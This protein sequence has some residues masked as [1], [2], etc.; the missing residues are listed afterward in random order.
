M[1]NKGKYVDRNPTIRSAGVILEPNDTVGNTLK[2]YSPE[3]IAANIMLLKCKKQ[4]QELQENSSL[5]YSPFLPNETLK[6][7]LSPELKKSRFV[8]FR[9]KFAEDMFFKK[10]V[11]GKVLQVHSKPED[12]TNESFVYGNR[13]PKSEKAYE[14]VLPK[15]TA[16][17]VNREYMNWHDKYVVSHRH[18]LPSERIKRK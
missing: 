6:D 1:A 13:K 17:Q 18:Y 9:E 4:T 7:L 15:K 5:G 8:A 2:I 3:E 14:L 12:Y 11:L 16:E 10:P